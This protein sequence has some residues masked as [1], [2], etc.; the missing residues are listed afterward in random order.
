MENPWIS[1]K[2]DRS[3][4]RLTLIAP[5]IYAPMLPLIRITLRDRPVLRDRYMM[6]TLEEGG[7]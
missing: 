2:P 7:Y 3:G 6:K 1:K 5:L 4:P